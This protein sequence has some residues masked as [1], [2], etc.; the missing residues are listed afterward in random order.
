MLGMA[1]SIGATRTSRQHP[2]ALLAKIA[3]HDDGARLFLIVKHRTRCS[4]YSFIR[5]KK[6][7]PRGIRHAEH[8]TNIDGD[9]HTLIMTNP[10]GSASVPVVKQ[11]GEVNV[12][13]S[14]FQT[15]QPI[16]RWAGGKRRLL[17][18]IRQALPTKFDLHA[19]NYFEPFFGAGAVG[20]DILAN[21]PQELA[22]HFRI[23]DINSDLINCLLY[24]SP[25]PRDGLLSR[26][27]SSA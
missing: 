14:A 2:H 20:L 27:P 9:A 19:H 11:N 8:V 21:Y 17:P 16:L 25:S 15:N 1:L 18:T 5:Q 7:S 3:E 4:F 24:T 22:S 6:P 26:M 10:A 12:T 13:E 23:N